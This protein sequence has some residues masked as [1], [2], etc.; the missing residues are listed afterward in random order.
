MFMMPTRCTITDIIVS[1]FQR[2]GT[3][4]MKTFE[5]RRKL[6]RYISIFFSSEAVLPRTLKSPIRNEIYFCNIFMIN[7]EL[8]I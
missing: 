7:N 3:G 1:K 8:F 4:K 5:T 2:D 6:D